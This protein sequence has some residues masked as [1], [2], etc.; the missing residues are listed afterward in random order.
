MALIDLS[1]QPLQD[2]FVIIADGDALPPDG[3]VLVSLSRWLAE[4]DT[5]GQRAG[6]VG[7]LLTGADDPL[8]LKDASE[9]LAL[10]AITFPKFADGRGYSIARL[11]RERLGWQGPLRATGDVLRTDVFYA[12][13]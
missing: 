2:T 10:I 1:G 4:R 5:L 7:A 6:A 12:R 13:A 9:G 3:D 11:V 8:T